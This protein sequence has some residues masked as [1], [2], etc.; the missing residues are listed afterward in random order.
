MIGYR[1]AGNF[2]TQLLQPPP[3]TN[4]PPTPEKPK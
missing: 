2:A 1:N 4:G 3:K